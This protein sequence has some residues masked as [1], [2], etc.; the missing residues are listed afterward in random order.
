[1]Q[2]RQTD[3]T[4]SRRRADRTALALATLAIIAA[5]LALLFPQSLAAPR[6]SAVHAAEATF[7]VAAP[8]DRRALPGRERTK[9]FFGFLEFDWDPDAPGGVPGFDPWPQ[10]PQ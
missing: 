10:A 3:T 1:M 2:T 4:T 6:A 5:V 9:W 7:A 8:D